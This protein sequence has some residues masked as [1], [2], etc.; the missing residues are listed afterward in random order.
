MPSSSRA[1]EE[2]LSEPGVTRGLLDAIAALGG[3]GEL[4]ETSQITF[5]EL[6]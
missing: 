2:L 4:P 6:V 3:L 1:A 5:G